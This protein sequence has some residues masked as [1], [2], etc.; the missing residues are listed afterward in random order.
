M[1]FVVRSMSHIITDE[2]YSRSFAAFARLY[3]YLPTLE[4]PKLGDK[5]SETSL[6]N[7]NVMI[8]LTKRLENIVQRASIVLGRGKVLTC[9]SHK[10]PLLTVCVFLAL[11][12]RTADLLQHCRIV[13][14]GRMLS[15]HRWQS[16]CD[17]GIG[18]A[19][20]SGRKCELDIHV[21]YG[22]VA[23][24]AQTLGTYEN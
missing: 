18:I 11:G 16:R 9:Q 20:S 23:S 4:N 7:D 5:L 15:R 12:G 21:A 10:F 2:R 24:F 3:Q 17:N 8:H 19:S 22:G 14:H 6:G 1:K 13:V